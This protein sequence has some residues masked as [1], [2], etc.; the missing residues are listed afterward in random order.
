MSSLHPFN[1]CGTVKDTSVGGFEHVIRVEGEVLRVKLN[2]D[3]WESRQ[4]WLLTSHSGAQKRFFSFKMCLSL[5]L[6]HPFIALH[7]GRNE[8]LSAGSEEI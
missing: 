3:M 7:L 6:H 5:A 1:C 2:D 4:R 8:D